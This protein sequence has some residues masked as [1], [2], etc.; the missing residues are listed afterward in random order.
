MAE[1]TVFVDEAVLGT[2]P[3]ICVKEGVPT[4]DSLIISTQVGGRSGIGIGWLL[5]LAGPLGWLGLFILALSRHPSDMLTV[6]LPFSEV[7][8]RGMKSARRG[9]WFAGLAS[10]G[11]FVLALFALS[12]SSRLLAAIIGV[13]CVLAL[14]RWVMG[15]FRLRAASVIVDLDAS[16]RWVTLSRV[17]PAFVESV[18]QDRQD[19][20]QSHRI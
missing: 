12:Q 6:R 16:R 7:A 8:H 15:L 1:A 4:T 11:F 20:H 3:Q 19:R 9:C 18:L 14:V 10:F 17:H 5:L 13:V 2:L